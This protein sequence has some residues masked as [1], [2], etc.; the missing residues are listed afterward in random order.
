MS[1]AAGRPV[2]PA[3][4]DTRGPASDTL[5][6]SCRQSSEGRGLG[7]VHVDWVD[8][9]TVRHTPSSEDHSAPHKVPRARVS[10]AACLPTKDRRIANV[11]F[12][13]GARTATQ[14]ALLAQLADDFRWQTSCQRLLRRWGARAGAR[15]RAVVALTVWAHHRQFAAVR[16]WAHAATAKRARAHQL[17]NAWLRLSARR[18]EALFARWR[19]RT[20]AAAAVRRR[21]RRV[22]GA[23]RAAP[24]DLKRLACLLG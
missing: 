9:C 13:E 15:R 22:G 21:R 1:C 23:A 24:Q 5:L 8:W 16:R 12:A 7:R 14:A 18:E 4:W 17:A 10:L 6:L 20:E 2:S 19:G 11:Q 3:P